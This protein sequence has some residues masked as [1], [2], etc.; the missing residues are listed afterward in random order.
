MCNF[1]ALAEVCKECG[2]VTNDVTAAHCGKSNC[3]LVTLA[4][5]AFAAINSTLA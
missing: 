1:E 3:L 4:G 2:M 5:D